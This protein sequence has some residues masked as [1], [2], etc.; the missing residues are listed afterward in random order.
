[1]IWI[2][3]DTHGTIDL[4][5]LEMFFVDEQKTKQITKDDYV[6]ILGDVGVC[7]DGKWGDYNLRKR[8]QELPCTVL[9]LDGNHENF[10]EIAKFPVKEWNGGKVHFITDD[11]IH[12]MRGQVFEIEGKKFFVM[13][14]GLSIDRWMRHEGKSW[15]PQEMPSKEEYDEGIKNLAQHDY[16][17]DYILTHT[18]P[19]EIAHIL[20]YGDTEKGEKE[21]NRYFDHIAEVTEFEKW[22]FGHWH[23]N[24]DMGKYQCLYYKVVELD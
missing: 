1:M 23:M 9:W 24:R 17:V 4:R 8:L 21:I 22:F 6:I 11:I 5:R 2:T 14:G 19:S 12:L 10:D 15:W 13:G 3:G 7:W 18:C 20:A 16:K